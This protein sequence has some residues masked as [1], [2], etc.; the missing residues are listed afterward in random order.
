MLL[1]ASLDFCGF[2]YP[3]VGN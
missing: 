1:M 2:L 3:L